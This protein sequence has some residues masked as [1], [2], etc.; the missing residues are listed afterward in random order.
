MLAV[1]SL[2][3][4]KLSKSQRTLSSPAYLNTFPFYSQELSFYCFDSDHF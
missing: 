1:E 3:I 2:R 4:S